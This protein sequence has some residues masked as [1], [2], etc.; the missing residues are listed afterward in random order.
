M[1]ASLFG[2]TGFMGYVHPDEATLTAG[3][4]LEAD[5]SEAV[6]VGADVEL[7]VTAAN[8]LRAHVP[9]RAE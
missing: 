3:Q 7:I 6:N 1:T 2:R 8:L 9:G 5:R 4:Q